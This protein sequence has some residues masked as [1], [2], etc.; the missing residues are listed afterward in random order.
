MAASSAA[1]TA[2]TGKDT[3]KETEA[4]Q[5]QIEKLQ[6]EKAAIEREVGWDFKRFFY[7]SNNE[8]RLRGGHCLLTSA[9]F[10]IR[11]CSFVTACFR[12]RVFL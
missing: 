11:F 3:G 9:I 2:A 7:L 12:S 1:F 5:S 10:A 6:Q 4:L 8:K